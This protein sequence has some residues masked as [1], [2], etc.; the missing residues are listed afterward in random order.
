MRYD[1][2]DGLLDEFDCYLHVGSSDDPDV[3][4]LTEF[5]VPDDVVLVRTEGRSTLV[6]SSLEFERAR[7][8]ASV[9][10]V[11]RTSDYLSG[12]R[13]G[14]PEARLEMLDGVL[15]DLDVSRVA[16]P[17]GFSVYLADGLRARGYGVEAVEDPVSEARTS[18]QPREVDAIA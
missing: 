7:R 2:V 16:V 11:R 18:K 9:D 8:E 5:D 1:G 10:V 17:R 4:Y 15:S 12:D 3:L 6:V 14:A 13:R